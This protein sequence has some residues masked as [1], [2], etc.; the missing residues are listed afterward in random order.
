M[1]IDGL[2]ALMEN[3]FKANKSAHDAFQNILTKLN[4]RIRWIEK[5]AY[6]AI[7]AGLVGGMETIGQVLAAVVK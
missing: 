1:D 2:H 5:V 7:G 6:I 4:G 3:G